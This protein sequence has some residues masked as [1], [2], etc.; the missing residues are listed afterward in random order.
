ME[1][2]PVTTARQEQASPARGRAP[3]VPVLLVEDSPTQR[4]LLAARLVAAGFM[5]KTVATAEEALET[6]V[7]LPAHLVLCDWMLP[8]ISGPEFCRRLRAC[9]GRAQGRYHYV[10]LLTAREAATSI[11]TGIEAGADDFLS[12]PVGQEELVA[13]L[14]AGERMLAM[15]AA[16]R[17]QTARAEATSAR[18]S[19]MQARAEVDLAIAAALQRDMLPRPFSDLGWGRV[20]TLWTPAAHIGGDLVGHFTASDG[21]HGVFALDASGDGVAAALVATRVADTLLAG[22]T[23][24]ASHGT[25]AVVAALN[26]AFLTLGT[27]GQSVTLALALH[28]RG[29]ATE[30]CVAGYCSPLLLHGGGG[31]ETL[32]LTGSPIGLCE[33]A[34]FGAAT[35]SLATGDRLLFHSDGILETTAADGALLGRARLRGLLADHAFHRDEAVLP[36]LERR[37]RVASA[38]R[39]PEDDISAIMLAV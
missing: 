32:E 19:E 33:T 31:V 7:D 6:L 27:H 10:L 38:D 35:V 16:L 15:R 29:G 17:A 18:L 30:V 12:K 37:L 8:G 11:E 24:C 5:V 22:G 2:T 39:A 36:L 25:H 1:G 4:R 21:R 26:R 14:G 3:R 20:A 9:E 28:Q 34:S 23:E 13:R